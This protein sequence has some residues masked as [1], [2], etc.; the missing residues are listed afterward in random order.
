[1]TRFI[2]LILTL[3]SGS[4]WA[5]AGHNHASVFADLTH[6]LWLAPCLIAIVA[7]N[8]K[9]MAKFTSTDTEDTQ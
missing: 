9:V 4:T 8:M 5:H 3:A 1:M 7:V 2:V 6:L